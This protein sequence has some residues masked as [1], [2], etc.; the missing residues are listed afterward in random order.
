MGMKNAKSKRPEAERAAEHYA[1]KVLKCVI[2]RRALR[3]KFAKVDFFASDIV[4]K[5]DNGE[6]VYIQATAGQ[7]SAVT[8]RRR[9]L[10]VIPW[11]F[12][13]TVLLV[14]LIQTIDP[15]NARRKKWFFRVHVFNQSEKKWSTLDEAV[16][17]PKDWFKAF[18]E[19]E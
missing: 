3:T 4:G 17:I 9:K 19:E 12:T 1:L 11:H 16:E 7:D 2:T 8:S 15:A 18:R 5:K 13:D 10:E 14:Q 6:H